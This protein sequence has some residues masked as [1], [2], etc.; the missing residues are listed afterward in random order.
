MICKNLSPG[1]KKQRIFE[2]N[3]ELSG[4]CRAT[5]RFFL[6]IIVDFDI[7]RQ[8]VPYLKTEGYKKF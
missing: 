4:L 8:S 6:S 7:Q 3:V 1:R 2:D 5:S